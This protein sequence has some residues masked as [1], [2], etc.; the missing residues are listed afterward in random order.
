MIE[1]G[2]SPGLAGETLSERR[3]LADAWWEDFE[4]NDPIELLLPGSVNCSHPSLAYE[5]KD[6][7]LRE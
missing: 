6:L 3:I 7:K 2:H 1:F 5:R 4:G